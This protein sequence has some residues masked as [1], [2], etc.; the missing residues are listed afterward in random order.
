MRS[1]N[2]NFVGEYVNGRGESKNIFLLVIN[3][4]YT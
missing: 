3:I 4:T 1:K 2:S